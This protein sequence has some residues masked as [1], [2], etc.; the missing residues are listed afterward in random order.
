MTRAKTWLALLAL[1][2]ALVCVAPAGAAPLLGTK[3]AGDDADKWMVD[4]A[5]FVFV[6][7]LKQMLGSDIMKKH[8]TEAAKTLIK[9][10]EQVKTI[11]EAAGLDPFKDV[12]SMLVSGTLG[13]RAAPSRG[14]VVLKGRFDPAKAMKVARDKKDDVEV[15][16]QGDVEL[17]KVKIQDQSAF[18]AFAGKNTLVIAQTKEATA[19]WISN[20]GKKSAK[21]SKPMKTA[22]DG[23]K[24]NESLTFSMIVT[25]DLKKLIA[26]VPQL[27]VAGPKLQTLTASLTITDAADLKVVGATSDAKAAKQLQGVVTVLK[28]VLQVTVQGAD[29][30][31]GAALGDILDAVKVTSDKD[32]VQ[33]SLK[34]SKEQIEKAGKGGG[35]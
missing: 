14:L 35:K 25:D 16:K 33:I 4:D 34:V 6:L 29:E 12:D 3:G 28:G 8:G 20:G 1:A 15:I 10:N 21:V 13:A 23:F 17:I 19:D 32:G 11:L 24:G 27:A 30:N 31:I 18:A 2:V 22:L 5:D 26:R 9:S 7:N